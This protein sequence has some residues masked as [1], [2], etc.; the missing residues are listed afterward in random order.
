[1]RTKLLL[2]LVLGMGLTAAT[3]VL[4]SSIQAAPVLTALYNDTSSDVT[5]KWW[6]AVQEQIR[7]DIGPLAI[8]VGSVDWTD[9]GENE[10]DYF[11]VSVA[12]AGDVN[13][14]GY[15]D[16]I[17]GASVYSSYRGKVYIYH[18]SANGPS[19]T[20]TL[21]ITGENAGDAFGYPVA[22]AG[23]V[24]GDG[25]ADVI[26][27]SAGASPGGGAYVYHGSSEGLSATAAFTA[28]GEHSASDFGISV[29][30]AGDVN[31]DGYADVAIGAVNYGLADQGK[32]Y[33]YHGSSEGLSDTAAFTVTGENPGDQFG[34]PVATA[35]D[36]NGDGY[37]D[38]AIGAA[39]YN[40]VRGKVYVYYGGSSGLTAT[41]AFTA[42]GENAGDIF[43]DVA[44][45]GDVN[46]DS[47]ADIIVGASGYNSYQGKA[48]IYH[49]SVTGLSVTPSFTVTGEND[50]D[51]FG[52]SVASAGDIN[53]DGYADVVIGANG[54]P[55]SSERGKVYV[56]LG[57]S[58]G[59]SIAAAFTIIGENT[60]DGFGYSVSGTGDLNGDGYTDLVIGAPH[61]DSR[62]K[63]YAYLGGGENPSATP[64]FAITGE[65]AGDWFGIS[66][67]PA[68]DVNGDG[69]T[70]IAVGA[71][72]YSL[73][74]GKVYVYHGSATG[75]ST[76]PAFTAT[77]ENTGDWFGRPLAS[78]GD[79][80]GDG[81]ADLAIGAT[82]YPHE[83]EWGR[84]YVYHGSATGL[85]AAPAFTAT[86]ESIFAGFGT[87][88]ASAGD[89]NGDGFSDL[90]VGIWSYPSPGEGKVHVYYGSASGLNAAPAFTAIG[91]GNGDGLGTSVASAGD[92]NG[93]GFADIAIGAFGYDFS[94]G[95]VYF[96]YG[97]A[98]GLGV[99]P[100]LT[101]IGENTGDNFYTVASAGDVN[102]DG[103]ADVAVGA[104]GYP[105]HNRRGK[106][107]VYHGSA[108]GLH[109]TPAF[110]ATGENDGDGFGAVAPAG[111][112][113]GDGYADVVI[114]ASSYPSP[115][116]IYVYHGSTVGLQATLA[117]SATGE[118]D[119]DRF[120]AM[121]SGGDIDGDGFADVII[122]APN[123]ADGQ[124]KIYIYH[125]GGGNGRTV[126]A[127]QAR[128]DGSGTPVQPWGSSYSLNSFE[129]SMH[130][131]NPMGRNRVKLQVQACPS[132]IPF[133]D[134][135]CINHTS[136]T[137]TDVTTAST[138]ITLTEVITGLTPGTLYRWRAR[139]LYA[140]LYV[141]AP[142]ITPPPNPAHGPWR[143]FQAQ[144][145]EADLRTGFYYTFLPWMS[146]N[147]PQAW[148]P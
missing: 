38:L 146:R 106:V 72:T 137:W 7:Q 8:N 85:S 93:D 117:F 15:A 96:Y 42:T 27:G 139:V 29:A 142:S 126:L 82:G 53:G 88:V 67:A 118:S 37:A 33:V 28:T 22:T 39:G 46:G 134:P 147:W 123:Y 138:G 95:K 5:G 100:A 132:G 16:V 79:V 87:S 63:A 127:H 90:I 59:L 62:G 48:Y 116:K 143:R 12:T 30:T 80:N 109:A 91:E 19:I 47:Y 77:G 104:M 69:F 23:D 141:T 148:K 94:R 81:F 108:S 31:G 24:N 3:G 119:G 111:D 43:C 60:G 58:T 14:D 35:G 40:S 57:E 122:G 124:G 51:R 101:I 133:G 34:I 98:S 56:Y 52:T 115:S 144:A 9:T 44:T 135:A 20:P 131:T 25:Y 140:P 21:T 145:M 49:G 75:L 64:A 74:K 32:V 97:S 113:N 50:D 1:M 128:G 10:G 65:N 68:G 114:G 84:V 120:G 78:A 89:V 17:V 11:G 2:S 6:A 125:G 41:A 4:T 105:S 129:V 26:V 73:G 130:A 13:G 102:N 83:D 112:V 70:D 136:T 107:Y 36:V 54:Y 45:A 66:V 110:S 61:Y 103:Y 71:S 86:G 76:T 121:A 55:S 18:G 99:T 92:V